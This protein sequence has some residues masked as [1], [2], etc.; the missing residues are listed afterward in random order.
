MMKFL[1]FLVFLLLPGYF[2]I[3]KFDI[4]SSPSPAALTVLPTYQG[5]TTTIASNLDIPWEITWGPDNK[6]WITEQK[7]IISRVDPKTGAKEVILQ[8]TDV[9]HYRTAGLLGLALHSDWKKYPY[10]YLNYNFK[11]N[12]KSFSRL[13]R[14]TFQKDTLLSPKIILEVD[15]NN[16]HSGSRIVFHDNHLFW[17]TG[18]ALSMTNSQD[19]NSPNGKILRFNP[20]GSIPE[21]NPVKGNPYWAMGFR[22][23]QGMTF[24][25]TGQLYISEHGDANDDEISLITKGRNYGWPVVQGF[26]ESEGEKSFKQANNTVDPM[27]A[28]TPTIGPAGIEYY[29]SNKIPAWKNSLLLVTLKGRSLRILKLS[30]DGKK[31]LEERTLFENQYGRIR[32]LCISPSGD[33]YISTSNRDWN[34]SPGFPIPKDDRIIRISGFNEETQK[35]SNPVISQTSPEVL[36]YNYCAA[37][38]KANGTGARG[39]FPPLA[40]SSLVKG[41]EMALIKKVLKGSSGSVIDGVKYD[42]QMPSFAFLKDEDLAT[43]LK[44][45]RS[46]NAADISGI[47]AEKIKQLRTE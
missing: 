11:R 17:A 16:G 23:I 3:S 24:S 5:D 12:D 26:A 21:D 44:Y 36:Y 39:L 42:A 2:L 1:Y 40:G 27:K 18:D 25:P 30:A 35:N 46:L 19:I 28:W 43:I 14:Y 13:V 10:V 32:D 22:N 37:C 7:G 9:L 34:P 47:N 8:L 45:I 29:N 15:A 31:I 6:I 20:D 38:H 33:V 4:S 41:E